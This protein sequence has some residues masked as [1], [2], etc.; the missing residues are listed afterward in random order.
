MEISGTSSLDVRVG[1]SAGGLVIDGGGSLNGGRFVIPSPPLVLSDL[2]G[3]ITVRESIIRIS[4][5]SARVGGG[6]VAGEGVLELRE[7]GKPVVDFEAGAE[8]VRLELAEGLRGQVSGSVR[9]QGQE[10]FKLS[11]ILRMNRG[12]FT[13]ELEEDDRMMASP[14][15]IPERSSVGEGDRISLDLVIVT[16][17]EL[18]VD[19]SLARLEAGGRLAI[20]GTLGSPELSGILSVEPDGTFN[21]GRNRFQ[22]L[23]GRVAFESYPSVLPTI[24]MSAMTKVGTTVIR[25]DLN[26][27][28]D[29]LQTKLSAPDDPNLSEGD[30][31]SLLVTGRTLE[32]AGEGGQQVASTWMMS[33]LADL[34]HEGWGQMFTFG[35]PAG[36]GPLIL[37]DE[38]NPT[39]RL[40]LGRAITNDLSVTYSIALD[41]TESQLWILDYRVA[42]DVWLRGI[43]ENGNQYSLGFA[44][45]FSIGRKKTTGSAE[46]TAVE[47]QIIS[48]VA[49]SSDVPEATQGLLEQVKVI[50]GTTYDY[51]LAQD[52]AR[53]LQQDLLK[54]GY[55]S[56]VVDVETQTVEDGI[57]LQF[58]VKPGQPVEFHWEG[59]DPG[60]D[61]KK[62]I[63]NEW[64]GRIPRS[65]LMADL[66]SRATWELRSDRYYLARVEAAAEQRDGIQR[67][68]FRTRRGARG[69]RVR[70]D[71]EGNRHLEDVELVEALPGTSSPQ[72]FAILD[73]ASE[74]EKGLRLRYASRGYLDT[75]V[76]EPGTSFDTESGELQVTI[77]IEEG[78]LSKVMG[79][80]FEGRA[81]LPDSE[82]RGAVNLEEGQPFN[83]SEVRNAQTTLR[84]HYRDKGFPDVKIRTELLPAE[85]GLEV[86]FHIEEGSPAQVGR[87]RIMGIR[88]TKESIVRRQLTFKEGDALRLSDL[89][90]STKNL[91]DLGV[92]RSADVRIDP[93]SREGEI[94]DIVVQIAER[95]SFD[96]SY[97]LRY[98]LVTQ[99]GDSNLD[100]N[101]EGIEGT[102]RGSYSN[103]FGYGSTLGV[104]AFVQSNRTLYRGFHRYPQF[105]GRRIPTEFIIEYEREEGDLDYLG[106][107]WSVAF[108]QTK[109]LSSDKLSV[110]WN[111][112]FGRFYLSGDYD[113]EGRPF[114][115]EEFR[116]QVGV[117]FFHDRRNSFANPTKGSFWNVTFQ[118]APEILGSDTSYYRMYTQLFYF[119]P[120]GKK[121]VWASSYRLGLAQGSREFLIIRDRFKAGGANSV[122][123]FKQDSLGPAVFVEPLDEVVYLGGQAVVVMNQELRFPIYKSVHGGVFYDTG[124][125]FA[126]VRD[127]RISALRHTAGAG[128]RLVLPFGALRLDWARILDL[129]EGEKPWRFHFAFG[130]AF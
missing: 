65:F 9:F 57:V 118:V 70:F 17:E 41:S 60:E 13:R 123:G 54:R 90:E 6:R 91:F 121:V 56:A 46:G 77:P 62:K 81:A 112:R 36:A 31:T 93:D 84:T 119:Y 76:G 24:Q 18:R 39:S 32:N 16:E 96:V 100:S 109:K 94:R 26:G 47:G 66:A 51:W 67:I 20:T 87:I 28:V 110:Q 124:N 83:L 27:E 5:L 82:L 68:V 89:Q 74:L 52:E 113:P 35:P 50:A 102:V 7:R 73:Q 22:I 63:E 29:D 69:R 106:R 104:Y 103:P 4:G 55:R 3:T 80:R 64:D 99:T 33:S 88:K 58:E 117:S 11:G 49:I 107:A 19:N 114:D 30:V 86:G 105:L 44:H 53:K 38:E 10:E 21:V 130:Y 122:R 97:G 37:A 75:S 25:L 115:I 71:F 126:N 116:S 111:Y 128:V 78:P 129:E 59:D 45:R 85:G 43:Q 14:I 101:P 108:Q 127:V 79:I 34:L 42:R 12:L 125:V 15:R 98:N 40:T 23:S 95:T 8:R 1:Q 61:L 120:L 48:N 92:F 2:G 72:F